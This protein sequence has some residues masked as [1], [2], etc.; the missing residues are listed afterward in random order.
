MNKKISVATA[1][2]FSLFFIASCIPAPNQP[3]NRGVIYESDAPTGL[4][5][6]APIVITSDADWAGLAS[7]GDGSAGS[8]WIIENFMIE[9]NGSGSGVV[10]TGTSDYAIIRNAY[11]NETGAGPTD[12]AF[13]VQIAENVVFRNITAESGTLGVAVVAAHN[14][15]ID[16]CSSTGFSTASL[17]IDGAWAVD[18]DDSMFEFVFSANTLSSNSSADIDFTN[19]IIAAG[20]GTLLTTLTYLTDVS[21][22]NCTFVDGTA[23]ITFDNYL[24]DSCVLDNVTIS[25]NGADNIW[26]TGCTG[27]GNIIT[28]AGGSESVL[29]VIDTTLNG[30]IALGSTDNVLLDG[31]TIDGYASLSAC[32]NV[33]ISDNTITAGPTAIYITGIADAGAVIDNNVIR[34]ATTYGIQIQSYSDVDIWNN[35]VVSC[36]TGIYIYAVSSLDIQDN[37]IR[38]LMVNDAIYLNTC[39]NVNVETNYIYA[40]GNAT[41]NWEPTG[42]QAA[43]ITNGTFEHNYFDSCNGSIDGYGISISTAATNVTVNYNTFDSCFFGLAA[44]VRIT[45]RY[46]T[47]IN[48]VADFEEQTVNASIFERNYYAEYFDSFPTANT[49]NTSMVELTEPYRCSYLRSHFTDSVQ[50]RYDLH[51][52]YNASLYRRTSEVSVWIYSIFDLLGVGFDL[53]HLKV[54]GLTRARRDFTVEH[55]LYHVFIEDAGGRALWDQVYNVND[56]VD[57]LVG[58][59]VV[60]VAVQNRFNQSVLFHYRLGSAELIVPIP[61]GES[62]EVRVSTGTLVWWV[63]DLLGNV[64]SDDNG[65]LVESKL[66]LSQDSITF[67]SVTVIIPDVPESDSTS[68]VALLAILIGVWAAVPAMFI[69]AI[70]LRPKPTVGTSGPRNPNRPMPPQPRKITYR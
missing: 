22:T 55:V 41:N 48:N 63:T 37:D 27:T 16:N 64:M 38:D 68:P 36:G 18:I 34:G 4:T 61:A 8:P 52:L 3:A 23:S 9:C 19:T 42:V 30:T 59:S 5:R 1:V 49:T 11:I 35:T 21:F 28:T 62:R 60:T 67:G 2:I 15:N 47:F 39:S 31:N 14:I 24:F 17:Y 20:A 44:W 53:I 40:P 46:N 25:I 12:I 70:K 10:V 65:T 6:H 7:S 58:L 69:I 33:T 45:A 56:T 32:S 54:D 13:G 50:T 57:L 66:I 29:G 43:T 51:P 26:F